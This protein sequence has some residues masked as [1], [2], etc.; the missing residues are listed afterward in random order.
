MPR[1][2]FIRVPTPAPLGR[3]WYPTVALL[4][5]GR[6]LIAGGFSDYGTDTCVGTVCTNSQL[7]TF[8]PATMTWTVLVD[9]S[10]ADEAI[11]P[12][13]REYTRIIV[14]PRPVVAGGRARH[15]LLMGKA[16]RVVLLSTDPSASVPMRDRL[17]RPANGARPLPTDV[18]PMYCADRSDQSTAVV[19]V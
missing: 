11:A 17:F 16:G 2:S 18:N 3:A 19:L 12:G 9:K 7:N 1:Q 15:V 6:L 10:A 5:D 13:I 8:D 4:P 14:L